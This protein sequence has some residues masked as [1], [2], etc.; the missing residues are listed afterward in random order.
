MLMTT[1]YFTQ[2]LSDLISWVCDLISWVC[3]LV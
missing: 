2:S 3:G 1:F